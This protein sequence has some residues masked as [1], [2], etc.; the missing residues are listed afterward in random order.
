MSLSAATMSFAAVDAGG[1]L[2]GPIQ[3]ESLYITGCALPDEALCEEF[4][5]SCLAWTNTTSASPR[6]AGVERLA[7][8]LCDHLHID[9]GLGLDSGSMC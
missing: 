1:S 8:A 5:L 7:C 4:F 3:D 6:P 2:F 9:T